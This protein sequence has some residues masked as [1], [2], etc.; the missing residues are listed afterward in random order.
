MARLI[1]ITAGFTGRFGSSVGYTNRGRQLIRVYQPNVFNPRTKRQELT[2]MRFAAL[3]AFANSISNPIAV[4]FSK[5]L[6]GFTRQSFI[7]VNI[8]VGQAFSGTSEEISYDKILIAKG[9]VAKPIAGQPSIT[10]NNVCVVQLDCEDSV[11]Y[12]ADGTPIHC[13]AVIVLVSP[14]TG[15][16]VYGGNMPASIS[17]K[18]ISASV[19][20]PS[21]L[22]GLQMHCYVFL[23]QS[24][25]PLNGIPIEEEPW[26]TPFNS[27]DSVYCGTVEI[28]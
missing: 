21:R 5:V 16:A 13:G 12:T 8:R 3:N 9:P 24:P 19:T 18:P 11:N 10:A 6:P 22:S 27:S 20:V 25:T 26:R 14:D 28:V 23:K 17:Q 2:R 1:G 15:L 7:G 4:G